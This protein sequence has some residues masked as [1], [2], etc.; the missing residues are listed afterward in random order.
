MPFIHRISLLFAIV[1]LPK[2]LAAQ[3]ADT[4][5]AGVLLHQAN[6]FRDSTEYAAAWEPYRQSRHLY[7]Q[8]AA[9]DRYAAATNEMGVCYRRAGRFSEAKKTYM[10]VLEL[11]PGK[12]DSLHPE[13]AQAYNNL[14]SNDMFMGA[15]PEAVAHLKKALQLKQRIYGPKHAEVAL[16]YNNLGQLYGDIGREQE[17]L[18]CLNRSLEIHLE[19]YGKDHPDVAGVYNNLGAVYY[20]LG[21]YEQTLIHMRK[22]MEIKERVLPARHPDLML[23]Y[24]N[25][26]FCYGLMGDYDLAID[27]YQRALTVSLE[28]L[29]PLHPQ[30]GILYNNMGN[31]HRMRNDPAEALPYFRQALAIKL[32]TQGPQHRDV[33]LTY[34]NMGQ[35]YGQLGEGE[36]ALEYYEK[37]IQIYEKALGPMSADLAVLRLN[38]G[39]LYSGLGDQGHALAEYRRALNITETAFGTEHPRTAVIYANMGASYAKTR[40][41]DQAKGFYEKSAAMRLRLLGPRHPDLAA[42]YQAISDIDQAT[43]NLAQALKVGEKALRILGEGDD[44]WARLEAGTLSASLR[45]EP[46]LIQALHSRASQLQA[47]ATADGNDLP[48]LKKAFQVWRLA[49]AAIDTVRLSFREAASRQSLA[50]TT[51][52]VYEGAIAAAMALYQETQETSYL[53]EVIFFSE[54]SKN[55]LLLEALK[56]AEARRFASLPDSLLETERR[57]KIELAYYDEK[58][59]S[60]NE[61]ASPDSIQVSRYY[62]RRFEHL[63]AYRALMLRLESEYPAYYHLKYQT[64]PPTLAQIRAELLTPESA[65]MAYFVGDSNLYVIFLSQETLQVEVVKKDFP[66]AEWVEQLRN[67]L[68]GNFVQG[69]TSESAYL[70]SAGEY[71]D[72]AT[73]LYERLFPE[74]ESPLP[75]RL[76]LIPDGV[77]GY[78]PFE[79]L[80]T[81][82]PVQ[83]A[84]F[85]SHAYLIRQYPI[86]Y[87]Y[88]LALLLQMKTRTRTAAARALLAFAPEFPESDPPRFATGDPRGEGISGMRNRLGPLYFNAREARSVARLLGGEVFEGEAATLSNFRLHAPDYQVLH[89]ATHG[90]TDD[91]FADFSFLAFSEG[92]SSEPGRLYVR[93]LYALDLHAEMVVL[94]ACESGIGKLYRGEGIVSMAS[95]FAYAGAASIL[96]TLWGVNDERSAAFMEKFYTHLSAGETKD[97]ALQKAKLAFLVEGEDFYA[98]PYYWA[99]YIVVGDMQ[100]LHGESGKWVWLLGGLAC[101]LLLAAGWA[102]LKIKRAN[103][104]RIS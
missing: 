76:T 9:W 45:K 29:G 56:E 46:L 33:G 55:L 85:S 21:D 32:E 22:A 57:L 80:L 89:I 42:D 91:Q 98:H 67:S 58:L 17:A 10:Q 31:S 63:R 94:S 78:L 25:T 53:E 66:L 6:T 48:A 54:K 30:T 12:L 28:T 77:L 62:L 101:L 82:R 50:A 44:D 88:S 99:G 72:V 5:Q 16:T 8:A 104:Q 74:N 2:L 86:S 70:A 95:G 18:D 69:E 20:A 97:E 71:A 87:G 64:D 40:A 24:N 36:T 19:V 47:V 92:D 90:K 65:I 96:T 59:R 13:V 81:E 73:R 51:V 100:P 49:V 102:L 61:T 38:V 83:P 14:G 39:R 23:G 34:N 37:A 41:F 84:A 60:L 1:L 68:Y 52:P 75:G 103:R 7:K 3:A 26:G 43:G 27:Y 15:Y 35:C 93:D 11:M 79:V 4:A